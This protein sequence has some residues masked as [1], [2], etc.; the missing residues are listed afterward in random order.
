MYCKTSAVSKIFIMI[1]FT[2]LADIWWFFLYFW[3]FI[4]D[5][6]ITVDQKPSHRTSFAFLFKLWNHHIKSFTLGFFHQSYNTIL[7][8]N[9]MCVDEMRYNDTRKSMNQSSMIIR[10]E[11]I[12]YFHA[13]KCKH[14][15]NLFNYF[16]FILWFL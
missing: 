5:S 15:T 10:N 16:R 13:H 3:F 8:I 11:Y 12:K 6:V 2:N 9:Q 4:Q 1:N 14:D 7:P